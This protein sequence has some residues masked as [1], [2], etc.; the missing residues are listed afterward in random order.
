VHENGRY[1]SGQHHAD[2][3]TD[4]TALQW[5]PA[6]SFLISDAA[7]A[8]PAATA[9]LDGVPN[10]HLLDRQCLSW[11]VI[12]GRLQTREGTGAAKRRRLAASARPITQRH[13]SGGEATVA[14]HIPGCPWSA[15]FEPRRASL[16]PFQI[17]WPQ[18]LFDA[19]YRC[20]FVLASL[21]HARTMLILPC[22]GL[23]CKR[24]V[25]RG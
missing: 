24:F 16:P 5:L 6:S 1:R 13:F 4:L 9:E 8:A 10:S 2:K 14:E 21:P 25:R 7:Q 18:D 11:E 17:L 19:R 12:R 22:G 20:S 3:P 15:R 23:F